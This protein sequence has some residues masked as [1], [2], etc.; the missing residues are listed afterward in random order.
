[1]R[2]DDEKRQ[3]VD[4]LRLSVLEGFN[5]VERGEGIELT[6]E[7][8]DQLIREADEMAPQGIAPGPDVID[9]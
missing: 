8:M 1:M 3:A 6:E 2:S 7:L 9:L 5:A 4:A